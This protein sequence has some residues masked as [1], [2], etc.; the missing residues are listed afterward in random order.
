[1]AIWRRASR[2]EGAPDEAPADEPAIDLR[3][4]A[5]TPGFGCPACGGPGFLDHIDLRKSVQHLHCKNCEHRWTIAET[6][7]V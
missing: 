2:D 3:E 5:T 4:Q 1:M 6:T 7:T